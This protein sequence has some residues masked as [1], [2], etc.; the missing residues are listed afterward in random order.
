MLKVNLENQGSDETGKGRYYYVPPPE[1]FQDPF[2]SLDSLNHGTDGLSTNID[3]NV[4]ISGK[5]KRIVNIYN[6]RL[7]SQVTTSHL[8]A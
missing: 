8:Q 3:L 5:S 7:L 6:C 4:R 2:E 1:S